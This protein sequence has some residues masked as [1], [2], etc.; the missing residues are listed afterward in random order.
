[1]NLIAIQPLGG[2]REIHRLWIESQRLPR[3]G[4][5]P[6]TPLEIRSQSG[7]LTLTPAILGENHVSSR[8]V[9]GGPRPII[10]L[11]NQSLL[12]GV[13]D[14]SEAKIIASYERFQVSPSHLACAIQR[15]RTLAPPF[16][17][18]GMFAGGGPLPVTLAGNAMK[19][20]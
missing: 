10:D 1:M 3:L 9:P 19:R 13:V 4:F 6:G 11:A 8:V 18:L 5:T 16:R 14:Y 2:N 12:A 20:T 7:Q 15:T 17:V